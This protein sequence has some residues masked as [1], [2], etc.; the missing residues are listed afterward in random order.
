MIF[1]LLVQNTGVRF[2]FVLFKNCRDRDP[3]HVS[4]VPR[5]KQS[6]IPKARPISTSYSSSNSKISI[7]RVSTCRHQSTTSNTFKMSQNCASSTYEKI[8]PRIALIQELDKNRPAKILP[9]Y[10]RNVN[11]K[12]HFLYLLALYVSMCLDFK[13]L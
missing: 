6:V 1:L 7:P 13:K 4:S 11:E 3:N 9:L 12:V 2:P 8:K 10:H 5:S